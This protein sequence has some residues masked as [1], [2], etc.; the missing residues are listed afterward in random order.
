[1]SAIYAVHLSGMG[2]W[3]VPISEKVKHAHRSL[4][5][6]RRREKKKKNRAVVKNQSFGL[7]PTRL[8]WGFQTGLADLRFQLGYRR[9]GAALVNSTRSL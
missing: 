6:R 9:N 7:I 8:K 3:S 2:V 5:Q 1:M 4:M